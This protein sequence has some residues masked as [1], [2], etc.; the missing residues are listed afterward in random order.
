M[1]SGKEWKKAIGYNG[2]NDTIRKAVELA[3]GFQL[4]KLTNDGTYFSLPHGGFLPPIIDCPQQ[5][6]DALAAQLVRQVDDNG[7]YA[8][9]IKRASTIIHGANDPPIFKHC[10]YGS[11]RTRNTIKAIVD[12]KILEK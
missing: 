9:V 10:S 11:D 6:L 4:S 8:V 5:Y 1:T 3:D 12:S 7:G 2:M